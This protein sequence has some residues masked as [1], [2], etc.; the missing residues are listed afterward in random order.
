MNLEDARPQLE[1]VDPAY[2]QDI[3]LVEGDIREPATADRVAELMEGRDGA[4]VVEDSEHVYDTTMASL[5]ALARYVPLNGYFV[6]EDG[7]VDVDE[8]RVEDDSAPRGPARLA[9]LAA[10][11]QGQDVQRAPRP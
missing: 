11:A 1:R 4:F 3:A 10:D 8:R 2:T 9:G 6:V 7:A 5:T